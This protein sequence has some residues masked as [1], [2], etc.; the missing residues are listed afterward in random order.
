MLIEVLFDD[1]IEVRAGEKFGDSD[2]MGMPY[3]VV[4]SRKAR[5]EGKFEV[6]TR[7]SGEVRF[8]SE[9]ELFGDFDNN[10]NT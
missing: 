3:R 8:L 2:L 10:P 5:D 9:E 1:R 6:V 4:A 7:A